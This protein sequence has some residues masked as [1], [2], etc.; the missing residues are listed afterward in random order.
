MA[1][2]LLR[3]AQPEQILFVGDS[4]I[5][6][7]DGLLFAD[8]SH[9]GREILTK[10]RWRA[11]FRSSAFFG[12]DGRFDEY[13]TRLW[14]DLRCAKH[15]R[16]DGDP[17]FTPFRYRRF[18]ATIDEIG[19]EP[20][21]QDLH[22]IVVSGGGVDAW[23]IEEEIASY[24]IDLDVPVEGLDRLPIYDAAGT[25]A[26]A[27]LLAT[28]EARIA[29]LFAG[30]RALRDAGFSKLFLLGHAPPSTESRPDWKPV[31]LRYCVRRLFDRVYEALC[32]DSGIRFVPVWDDLAID[33]LRDDRY[34][35]DAEHVNFEGATQIL[36]RIYALHETS[37][38][39]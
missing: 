16:D 10:A 38:P 13:M 37:L 3:A 30:M 32:R 36:N 18:G 17:I 21:G 34:F 27:G 33:G 26:E 22:T 14:W 8:R 24:A 39:M 15:A 28:I 31:R 7:F 35:E 1:D 9:P 29:P 20:L 2:L 6:M 12:D 23:D 5:R 11:F 25:I 19:L 4:R